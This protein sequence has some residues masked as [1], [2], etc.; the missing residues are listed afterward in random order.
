MVDYVGILIQ[1][2][3]RIHLEDFWDTQIKKMTNYISLNFEC[4]RIKMG[5]Q[6]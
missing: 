3:V 5:Y 2:F 4:P 1:I 6:E